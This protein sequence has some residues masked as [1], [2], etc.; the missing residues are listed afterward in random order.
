MFSIGIRDSERAQRDEEESGDEEDNRGEGK[1]EALVC[2]SGAGESSC[3]WP[4]AQS[5]IEPANLLNKGL[6][7]VLLLLTAKQN[8]LYFFFLTSLPSHP[9]GS[10]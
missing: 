2:L 1:V 4:R 3:F 6:G 10:V 5:E 7:G 8:P 9:P